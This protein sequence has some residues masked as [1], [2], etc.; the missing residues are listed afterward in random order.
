[1]A[2]N[3]EPFILIV[4]DD[5][6]RSALIQAAFTKSMSHATLHFVFSTWEARAYLAR[7]SPHQDWERCPTPSLIVLSLA[8]REVGVMETLKWMDTREGL[9]R[10]RVIVFTA[11]E[12]ARKA[13]GLRVR[14]YM[15]MPDDYSEL[16]V[17]V[18]EELGLPTV[19]NTTAIGDQPPHL[20]GRQIVVDNI[21]WSV[22]LS[23]IPDYNVEVG[24]LIM[25]DPQNVWVCK[26]LSGVRLADLPPHSVR[27]CCS[28]APG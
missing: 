18:R 13:H 28:G 20:G 14:R 10:I 23:P 19:V 26:K 6:E 7:E 21:C 11:P 17:A 16:V 25:A 24:D 1:M 27:C 12:H 15:S 8:E 3:N 22:A 5:P 2:P 4:E 9:A